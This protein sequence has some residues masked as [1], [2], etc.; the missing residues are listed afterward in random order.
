M[1]WTVTL[2]PQRGGWF[3]SCSSTWTARRATYY[4]KRAEGFARQHA[5]EAER[6]RWALLPA[7]EGP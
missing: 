4:K 6:K 3:A 7:G 2:D 1:P 5:E